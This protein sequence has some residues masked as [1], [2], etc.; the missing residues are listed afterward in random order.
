MEY[1]SYT[2]LRDGRCIVRGVCGAEEAA[3]ITEALREDVTRENEDD[4]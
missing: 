2:V 1:G 3:A 4:I